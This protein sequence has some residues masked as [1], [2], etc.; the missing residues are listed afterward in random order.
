METM[1][2][3]KQAIAYMES[4]GYT[5]S[6][7]RTKQG[8]K[9]YMVLGEGGFSSRSMNGINFIGYVNGQRDARRQ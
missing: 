4:L 6:I 5:V 9:R 2:N 3:S 7:V 1:T 8:F